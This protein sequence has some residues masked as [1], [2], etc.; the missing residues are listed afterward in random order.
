MSKKP[1][2]KPGEFQ[3]SFLLPKYWGI[4]VGII[5]LM[6]LAILP[7]S[8]QHRIAR[9]L[10]SIAFKSL[11]SRKQTTIRNLE[12][13]FP[14]WS[15]AEVLEK[16]EQVFIDQMLGI[17]ETLNAWYCPKWFEGRVEIEGL[18]H[19]QNAQAQGK[20][21]LLLGTHSTLLDAGGY[22]CA[23]YFDPD[24]VY[25]PQNNP[26]L[27]MLIYRCR[28][29]IYTNQIDHDDMRGLIRHLKN[30]RAIWY[31]PDQDFGLKQGVMAPFFGVP[32]AT[33]TAH[34]RLL[35]MTKAEAIPLYFYRDGN[36][37]NPKYKVLIE[38]PVENLPS[39]DELD[40]ATRTNLIIERQLRIAPTQYMWFHRRFKTRP[41][42]SERLY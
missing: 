32:A 31:S 41:N 5:F 7:W 34:R 15:E 20:G 11:K 23:Q 36:I 40:D 2:Y 25:R 13:C 12:L 39:D 42:G 38:P 16:S 19:I 30:G 21:A 14:E 29:T 3:W 33:V 17:F 35:K 26:L 24:V 28:S 37:S 22:V 4:W 8:I 1:D 10:G 6:I 27:D 18:E 9:V